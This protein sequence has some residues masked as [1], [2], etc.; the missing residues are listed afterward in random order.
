MDVKKAIK[1]ATRGS[2]LFRPMRDTYQWTFNRSYWTHRKQMESFYSQFISSN[3]LV[4]DIGAN[5]GEYT[6]VFVKLGARVVAV[7][8]NEKLLPLLK[9]IRPF[10]RVIVESVALGSVD[11]VADLH[12][13]ESDGLST[14]SNAW[15]NVAKNSERFQ[16]V[17]WN[18]KVQVP[19]STLDA[20]I[21][22]YGMPSFIK[23][24][25]EG[26]ENQVLAG[27]SHAPRFLSFEINTEFVET[28]VACIGQGC[29][30]ATSEFN[31]TF[32]SRMKLA[33]DR[34]LTATEMVQF[35]EGAELRQSKTYGDILVRSCGQTFNSESSH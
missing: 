4:F 1:E 14:L 15:L 6:E 26:Y 28:A 12:M 35:L 13:C 34:W 23:I 20:L 18:R 16:D 3:D 19:V 25:V 2:V 24:D 31:I 27:L 5:I 7:E 9:T 17:R 32:N 22:R 30:P 33:N 10:D 21:Q 29:F 8:P 11:G